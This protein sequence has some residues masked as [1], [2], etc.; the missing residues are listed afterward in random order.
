[1]IELVACAEFAPEDI[2]VVSERHGL[3][4]EGGNEGGEKEEREEKVIKRG[5]GNRRRQWA[6]TW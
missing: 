6:H 2:E 1:M 3:W 4:R 5:R